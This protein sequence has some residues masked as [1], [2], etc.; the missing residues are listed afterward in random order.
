M[1]GTEIGWTERRY[2]GARVHGLHACNQHESVGSKVNE[3]RQ[4]HVAAPASN[5]TH[6]AG[7]AISI[8]VA[9]T[10]KARAIHRSQPSDEG[11]ANAPKRAVCATAEWSENAT[12]KLAEHK[13]AP[14]IHWHELLFAA[15]AA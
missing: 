9:C 15:V 2:G 8:I 12:A 6:L 3:C 10:K 14:R 1:G 5:E 7:P 11:S 4:C 13:Q